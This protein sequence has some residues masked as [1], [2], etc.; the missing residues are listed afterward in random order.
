MAIRKRSHPAP[1]LYYPGSA[2][3]LNSN[4]LAG[5]I[6]VDYNQL[7]GMPTLVAVVG[8]PGAE[9]GDQIP[10]PITLEDNHSTAAATDLVDLE[11]KVSD[12]AA[13]CEPSETAVLL[14]GGV[15]IMLAGSGTATGIYRTSAAGTL[16]IV[17]E[18]AAVGAHRFLWIK[19]G[20]NTR[21]YIVSKNGVAEIIF[22]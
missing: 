11:I 20:G 18:E 7:T 16:E 2:P 15:G 1:P 19:A 8:T 6:D 4:Q 5:S 9:V 22:S 10:V 14:A 17:V 21:R 13:L 12:G 3:V